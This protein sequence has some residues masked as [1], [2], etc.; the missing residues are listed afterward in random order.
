MTMP[1][2]FPPKSP[3]RLG[4]K[5]ISMISGDDTN[6]SPQVLRNLD[7]NART[8]IQSARNSI[9]VVKKQPGRQTN[10]SNYRI[11]NNNSK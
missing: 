6:S 7:R 11:S 4:M 9:G 1:L 10:I 2:S 8:T 5:R 3:D